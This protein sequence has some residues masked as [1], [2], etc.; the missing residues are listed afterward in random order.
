VK[1][2]PRSLRSLAMTEKSED[3]FESCFLN[4]ILDTNYYLLST[5][6]TRQLILTDKPGKWLT[7]FL[8]TV[9]PYQ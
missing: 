5:K 2:L 7:I 1:G 3:S 8:T 6:F 4:A 9:N